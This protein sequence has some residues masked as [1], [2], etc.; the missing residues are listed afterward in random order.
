MKSYEERLATFTST[1]Y[2]S[3]PASWPHESP[4]PEQ[5]AAAGFEYAGHTY[6]PDE[7]KCTACDAELSDWEPHDNPLAEH[8]RV[9]SDTPCSFIRG[10]QEKE[11]QEA[12]EKEAQKPTLTSRDLVFFDP[13]L[14]FDF[15]KLRLYH[16]INK[17]VEHILQCAN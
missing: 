2:P 11:S 6:Y 8:I 13:S 9:S 5:L 16:N 7:V 17:F 4:K 1:P 10:I 14:Q 12:A 15:S 3:S